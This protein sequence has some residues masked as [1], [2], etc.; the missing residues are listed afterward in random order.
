MKTIFTRMIFGLF[1][2]AFFTSAQCADKGTA[3][4]AVALAKKAVEAIKKDGQEKAF[5]QFNDPKGAFVKG[6]L[7]VMSY[8]MEGNNK[9][10]GGNAK[11][12]GK[13]LIDIKD[14]NGVFIVQEL[15]K[16]AK[17]PAGK[18]WVDYVWVNT[19]TKAIEPKSTY[20]EKVGDVLV[21][22]GIYK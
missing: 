13:N 5:A 12:I 10:H 7:Y 19:V 11:L 6:D 21:G 20:V 1:A 17:S 4:E 16:T 8:D 9:A 18:G 2:L 3:D 22:V 15:I 14:K